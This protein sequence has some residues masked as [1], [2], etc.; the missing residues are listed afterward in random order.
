MRHIDGRRPFA[1]PNPLRCRHA[2]YWVSISVEKFPGNSVQ[3]FPV[4]YADLDCFLRCLKR[5]DSFP[6]SRMSQW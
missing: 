2:L 5:K 6:V 3:K 1:N 4:R